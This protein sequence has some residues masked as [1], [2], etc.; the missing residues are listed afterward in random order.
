MPDT[1]NVLKQLPAIMRDPLTYLGDMAVAYG[2][3]VSFNLPDEKARFI[4][5]PDLIQYVLQTNNRNYN[6]RT[7]QFDTFKIVAGNG[8]LNSDG[9]TW[10]QRR[11]VAQPAFHRKRL[12]ALTDAM[13]DE[14]VKLR[15]RWQT[16]SRYRDFVDIEQEMLQLTLPILA[17][18]LF[19]LD[20]SGQVAELVHT[21]E[22]ALDYVMF[23]ARAPIP[24]IDRWPL[25]VNRRFR[26][27][28]QTI[29]TMAY[30]LIAERR[31]AGVDRGDVLSLFLE[32]RDADTGEPMPDDAIRDEVVTL[33]IA[34]YETAATGL[35]WL[36]YLLSQHPHIASKLYEELDGVLN[37]RLPTAADLEN[38]PY[39]RG[40]V[41]ESW[42]I[43][44]PSWVVSRAAIGPDE[45]GGKP[46]ASGTLII[47]SP[48]VMH[49]NP[50]FW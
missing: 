38:L 26:Q 3:N 7:P 32:A 24:T 40:V 11:R 46:V 42:R 22:H 29:D 18:T 30:E 14:A 23:R 13:V 39:L 43:Y 5:H 36:W 10:L 2:D 48:Y 37:G 1:W 21:I 6:K 9:D 28:M 34:G 17:R 16:G 33:I 44:P 25:P 31:R 19:D 50:A 47:I 8:L 35:T 15:Q 49:R 27:A 20:V 41:H 12:M 4:N 45:I